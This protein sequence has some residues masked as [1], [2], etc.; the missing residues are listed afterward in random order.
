M[1]LPI[2]PLPEVPA[3]TVRVVRKAFRKGHPWVQ[4][5]DE[6]PDL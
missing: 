2:P 6:L 1:S 3:E 5:R 4:L